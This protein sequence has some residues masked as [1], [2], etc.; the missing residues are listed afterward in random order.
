MRKRQTERDSSSS[1]QGGAKERK[2]KVGEVSI[3]DSRGGFGPL[4]HSKR[5]ASSQFHRWQGWDETSHAIALACGANR[6]QEAGRRGCL[7][8]SR[9]PQAKRPRRDEVSFSCLRHFSAVPIAGSFRALAPPR[10]RILPPER[11]SHVQVCALE[12]ASGAEREHGAAREGGIIRCQ[13]GLNACSL[14][15]F[16][17]CF[18]ALSF[19]L[20]SLFTF[21]ALAAAARARGSA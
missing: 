1:R 15:S 8:P 11:G 9:A 21:D 6:A 5:R 3:R 19:S 14:F 17:I 4:A 12:G 18:Q 16:P 2:K 20:F 13:K 7:F 10:S